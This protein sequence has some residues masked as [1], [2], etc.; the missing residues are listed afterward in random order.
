MANTT[1]V[2]R[3]TQIVAAWLQDIN[4]FFYV[5]FAGATTAAQA[6]TA[7]GSTSVG[8]SVFTAA[9]AAAARTAIGTVIGTDVQAYDAELAALAGTTS[10]ADKVPYFTGAGTANTFTAD[11]FG[12]GILSL[13]SI[14]AMRS[15]LSAQ[16]AL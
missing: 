6:R 14:A 2:A 1:F 8:D 7:L 3:T 5:L 10:A 4:D 13:G 15:Y 16:W 9:N 11:A 12:R